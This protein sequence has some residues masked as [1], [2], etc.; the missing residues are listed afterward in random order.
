MGGFSR[1]ITGAARVTLPNTSVRKIH[2]V[3]YKK[4]TAMGSAF[5]N[6]KVH[7]CLIIG[8]QFYVYRT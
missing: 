4:K 3:L 7:E 5:F 6:N 2:F 1:M 8:A